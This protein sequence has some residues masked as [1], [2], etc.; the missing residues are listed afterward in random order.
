LNKKNLI[1][2]KNYIFFLS[3]IA[4]IAESF[5][6]EAFVEVNLRANGTAHETAWHAGRGQNDLHRQTILHDAQYFGQGCLLFEA[7]YYEP[8]GVLGPLDIRSLG[9]FYV[10]KVRLDRLSWQLT[11]FFMQ[12][13]LQKRLQFIATILNEIFISKQFQ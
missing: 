6:N 8:D 7:F 1:F 12:K 10:R 11:K 4:L 9:S 5:D 3:L 2:A 13:L